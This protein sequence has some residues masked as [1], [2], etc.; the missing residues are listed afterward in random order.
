M[1]EQTVFCEE[2]VE[3]IPASEV[4]WDD[5]RLYCRRCGSELEPP[6]RD[7]F[8]EIVDNRSGFVFRDDDALPDDDEEDEE[9]DGDDEDEGEDAP[10]DEEEAGNDHRD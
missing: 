7:I 5:G 4:Y 8:E 2:C 10:I 9:D 1:A 3:E 6:D